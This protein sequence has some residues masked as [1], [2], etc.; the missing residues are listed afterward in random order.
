M[1]LTKAKSWPWSNVFSWYLMV[2]HELP[3]LT[4]VK[5]HQ[6]RFFMVDH[7]PRI[8]EHGRPWST[9][10]DHGQFDDHGQP[11]SLTMVDDGIWW[12][13]MVVHG[14]PS[15]TM[16]TRYTMVRIS[17]GRV[18][19]CP[20]N[21]TIRLVQEDCQWC[22]TNHKVS[23]VKRVTDSFH[24]QRHSPH[25]ECVISSLFSFFNVPL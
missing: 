16:K 23:Y 13:T 19:R 14:R 24:P 18:S 3:W 21:F 9:M 2:Y 5:R 11:W 4:M 25:S 6:T 17:P 1:V 20:S 8:N 10:F 22:F 15:N 12:M 7:G